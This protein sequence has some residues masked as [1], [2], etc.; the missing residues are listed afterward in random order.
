MTSSVSYELG[1]PLQLLDPSGVMVGPNPGLDEK[2]LIE[3]YRFMVI[4]R[5]FCRER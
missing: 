3:M 4:S 5:E 1:E 2:E